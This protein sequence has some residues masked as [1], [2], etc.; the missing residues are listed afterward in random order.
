MAHRNAELARLFREMAD[1]L[2][3]T[4]ANRFKV[5]AFEKA[6]NA[7]ADL[8]RD[9][10]DI[11]RGELTDIDGIG[12]G[13][14][15][16]IGEF[17]DTGAIADHGELMAEV[18]RGLL[19][20]LDI[21]GLGAKTVYKL[22]QEA[23]IDS[24][25]ALQRGLDDGT[26]ASLKGL[27]KKKAEQI[28]ENLA[29][30]ESAGQ[31]VNIGVARPLAL[32]LAARLSKI[33][34]VQRCD[35][36]GSLRRGRETIGDLDLLV[37]ADEADAKGIA[38]AF[39]GFDEVAAVNAHGE[40]KASIR[41]ADGLQCDLRI[42]RPEA[43]GAALMYF[44]GSKDHNVRLRER[45]IA[46]GMKL[47]EYGLFAADNDDTPLV[48]DT[49]PAIYDKLGLPWI[50]PELREDHGEIKRAE[51]GELPELIDVADRRAELHAHT[52]ASDGSLS[53]RELAQ[54]AIDRGLHTQAVTDHSKGQAQANGLDAKRLAKHVKAIHAVAEE[55]ADD[56]ALLAGSEVDILADGSLDYDDD[57][58]A[59][60]DIVVASP[61]AALSQDPATATKRLIK[62][63][64]HPLVRIIGHPTG[65]LINRR[66]GLEPDMAAVVDAA[67]A[68]DV[69]LE[70]N[71][72]HMRLDLRDT[73]ARLALDAGVK[74]AINTDAHGLGDFDEAIYG[75]LT[76]RRAGATKADVI[77]C[78][79]RKQ[80][81]KWLT[82]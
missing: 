35:Y 62:A 82:R 16:R 57:T 5:I 79:T 40:K 76:A 9:V 8:P 10:A 38:D 67:K 12:K 30:I 17:L 27:G 53:I 6:A 50:P 48:A 34:V 22:W 2:Q 19:K 18:P 69:A 61:H 59:L 36:A 81:A 25:D 77:N 4:G 58:L 39:V 29:F 13:T 14:A 74:L 73:H 41:T 71:A 51:A 3:L 28:K 55:L 68:N 54:A 32:T 52:T 64:E 21:P 7:V 44:T 20:L 23:D 26:V 56:I 72:H 75:V 78:M 11:P 31:R 24:I 42:V 43:Y 66:K 15:D 63:I 60:L 65:R 80:L 70:I 1:V 37:A 49:E 45:A 47:S 46:M 33:D